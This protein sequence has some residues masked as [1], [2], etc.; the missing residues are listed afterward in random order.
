MMRI[1]KENLE[2]GVDCLDV[3]L[4]ICWVIFI[5][6]DTLACSRIFTELTNF[7]MVVSLH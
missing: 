4:F 5:K 6:T 1:T 2:N 7:T 3:I